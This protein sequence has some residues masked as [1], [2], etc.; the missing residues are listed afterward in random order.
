MP[1]PEPEPPTPNPPKPT[2]TDAV[3]RKVEGEWVAR[4]T[5]P[6]VYP[7]AATHCAVVKSYESRM[8]FSED[9]SDAIRGSYEMHE[10]HTVSAAIPDANA[11]AVCNQL[12]TGN[13]STSEFRIDRKASISLMALNGSPSDLILKTEFYECKIQGVS[14][15]PP[16]EFGTY[17]NISIR[18]SG[19][20]DRI[21]VN[22][23]NFGK[24]PDDD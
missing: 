11:P 8:T 4:N 6:A 22:D 1:K 3:F 19:D 14:N 21:M 15:C 20:F 17:P 7:P 16:S 5:Y 9:A 13:P 23:M 10:T 24:A 18:V 12:F 2:W